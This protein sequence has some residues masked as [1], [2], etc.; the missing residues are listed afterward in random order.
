MNAGPPAVQSEEGKG[1]ARA[2]DPQSEPL[3]P[4]AALCSSARTWSNTALVSAAFTLIVAVAMLVGYQRTVAEDPLNAHTL[5]RLREHLHQNPNDEEIRA[6]ALE[7][8]GALTRW[9]RRGGFPP[10]IGNTER[11]GCA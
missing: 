5:Q 9:L 11:R 10:T 3:D 8:L 7:L 4:M 6:N 2:T 1:V